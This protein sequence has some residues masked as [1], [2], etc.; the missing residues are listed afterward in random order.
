MTPETREFFKTLYDHEA[1]EGDHITFSTQRREADGSPAEWSEITFAVEVKE[2]WLDELATRMAEV[3]EHH[4]LYFCVTT[5]ATPSNRQESNTAHLTALWVDFD[6]ATSSPSK[7]T[8]TAWESVTEI[9]SFLFNHMGLLDVTF[10]VESGNGWHLYWVL[11]EP[12]PWGTDGAAEKLLARFGQAFQAAV[13][14]MGKSLDSVWDAARV[15]RVPGTLNYK[16]GHETPGTVEIVSAHSHVRVSPG[17]LDDTLPAFDEELGRAFRSHRGPTPRLSPTEVMGW[18]TEHGSPDDSVEGKEKIAQ[19]A[20]AIRVAG[21]GSRHAAAQSALSV[22]IQD[23]NRLGVEVNIARAVEPRGE[24]EKVWLEVKPDAERHE[25]FNMVRHTVARRVAEAQDRAFSLDPSSIPVVSDDEWDRRAAAR[26]KADA[27]D[28][29]GDPLPLDE[30]S[31]RTKFYEFPIDDLPDGM[32]AMVTQVANNIQASPT[33]AALAA[34]ASVSAMT[35]SGFMVH[36]TSAWQEPVSL[37][38]VGEA[39]PSER[40][41]AALKPFAKAIYE[42]TDAVSKSWERDRI[43]REAKLDV[44][45]KHERNLTSGNK[46][47]DAQELSD[48][49][50]AIRMA[51]TPEPKLVEPYIVQGDSTPE[52]MLDQMQDNNGVAFILSAEGGFINTIAGQYRDRGPQVD[53]LNAAHT[54][55]RIRQARVG[56]GP[57][58]VARNVDFPHLVILNFVQPTVVARFAHPDFD[59]T[60]F[61]SRILFASPRGLA[62]SRKVGHSPMMTDTRVADEWTKTITRIFRRGWGEQR[63]PIIL[64]FSPEARKAFVEWEAVTERNTLRMVGGSWWG[65]AHGH[66]ARLAGVIQLADDPDS[67][68]IS[69]INMRRAIR[70]TEFFAA[71]YDALVGVTS[72]IGLSGVALG[73][74]ANRAIRIVARR[75]ARGEFDPTRE[76]MTLRDLQRI[77]SLKDSDEALTVAEYLVARR[78]VKLT[79]NPKRADSM[80]VTVRPD[81]EELLSVSGS[82]GYPNSETPGQSVGVTQVSEKSDPPYMRENVSEESKRDIEKSTLSIHDTLTVG[83]SV[84]VDTEQKSSAHAPEK[85]SEIVREMERAR[86]QALAEPDVAADLARWDPTAGDG[87]RVEVPEFREA[88][89]KESQPEPTGG[90]ESAV[91]RVADE[92]EPPPDISPS[93]TAVPGEGKTPKPKRGRQPKRSAPDGVER[94]PIH[95]RVLMRSK[96]GER[97]LCMACAQEASKEA[98]G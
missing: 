67:G 15:L 97:D 94:C 38:L 7:D 90:G 77:V 46:V 85:S 21:A 12:M 80:L 5:K 24:L 53:V 73:E 64:K 26:P 32:K 57:K 89:E 63:D 50:Y 76:A 31:T 58:S 91:T 96:S 65:K 82:D 25:W 92:G 40:K 95:D 11:D 19:A 78:W 54:R 84:A 74:K 28:E 36:V 41:S 18:L 72:T 61:L 88:D 9:D 8:Q 70:V 4:D 48:A 47:P 42:A 98:K 45:R 86:D 79:I 29:W 30:R 69:G 81:V 14:P 27:P 71:E 59:G 16:A 55:E 43:D 17:D 62:G 60:G 2:G 33:L 52:A 75:V 13:V 23:W 1:T 37:W 6:R 35:A 10:V 51:E 83:D 93:I 34:L 44:L 87:P 3:P 20:A 68:E 49:R 39:G 56:K 22:L 66:A